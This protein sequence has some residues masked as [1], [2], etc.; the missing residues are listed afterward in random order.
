MVLIGIPC[1]PR[2]VLV[3]DGQRPTDKE[4]HP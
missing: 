4:D 2:K 1:A 3:E